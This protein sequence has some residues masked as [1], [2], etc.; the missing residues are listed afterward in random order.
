MGAAIVGGAA[1][2][3]SLAEGG[4]PT[5]AAEKL[6][7]WAGNYEYSVD[8][9]HEAR[10]AG[11]VQEFVRGVERLRA[12]GTRHCFNGIADSRHNLLSVRS[13]AVP[14]ELDEEARTVTV[15]AGA[16]Y[17]QL[18]PWLDERGF[19]LHNLASLPHISVAGACATATHGSGVGN[20]NLATAVSGLELVTASGELRRI[21]RA[22]DPDLFPGAVVHLGAL[23]VL[24]RVTLDVEPAY[25]LRQH[26]YLDLPAAELRDHFDEIMSA[27]Y[28]VSLFTGW[29]GGTVDEVWLKSRHDDP[30]SKAEAEPGFFGARPAT[31]DV[32]PIVALTAEHCTEQLGVEGPWY[33]RLPHFRMGFTPSSGEELQSEYFV[34]LANAVEAILAIERLGERVAP[35]LFISELRTIAADELWMS[36]AQG[37]DSLAIHFTWKPDWPAVRELLPLIERELSPFGVRPHWGKLFTLSR[38]ELRSRYERLG[39]FQELVR[40]LDPGGKFQNRFLATHL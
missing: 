38:E 22:G 20:G 14:V 4:Q 40:D 12:L 6:T 32:H 13:M 33:E 16:S 23:G 18:C 3:R 1:A 28:S 24:T 27:G 8:R 21:S 34:P 35:H 26:V 36:T 9:I 30:R 29:R 31:R 15:E 39:E 25:R 10:T 11:E 2:S 17:G 37:R 5:G 7:N 19:A